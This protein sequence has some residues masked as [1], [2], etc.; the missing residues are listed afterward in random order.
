[1][2]RALLVTLILSF[3]FF[4]G[5]G[6][7]PTAR[8]ENPFAFLVY[9][10][11][12]AGT[13]IMD[14]SPGFPGKP[15]PTTEELAPTPGAPF[16][17][18]KDVMGTIARI[19]IWGDTEDIGRVRAD[20]AFDRIEQ[21]DR[22]MSLFNPDSTLSRINRL[23]GGEPVAV[24]EDLMKVLK[25]AIEIAKLS[26]GAFD[27]T[28]GPL[29]VL[30]RSYLEQRQIP[31]EP[32]ISQSKALVDYRKIELNE[33]EMT[34]RLKEA[35]MMLDLGAIAKGYAADSAAKTLKA[36]G[37]KTAT[38]EIGGD[39]YAFGHKPG[40][41][42]FRI[43]IENPYPNQ[44]KPVG[45]VIGTDMGVVTSGN[46]SQYVYLAGQRYSHFIDPRSGRAIA[47]LASCTVTGPDAMTSDAMATT[48]CVLGT[49]PGKVFVQKVNQWYLAQPKKK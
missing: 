13:G 43:P 42:P 1:M 8:E 12:G 34:V 6:H 19:R 3:S 22:E 7:K 15:F 16:L 41:Q 2:S 37:V 26:N 47:G 10:S 49:G 23:A 17:F 46:Y 33:K 30:W 4:S 25:R 21:V 36:A 29:V 38:V 32:T 39:I 44:E 24:D 40:D 5:C 18:E 14:Q 9:E 20:E 48:V 27:P 35:G 28:V 31:D 11:S 45:I